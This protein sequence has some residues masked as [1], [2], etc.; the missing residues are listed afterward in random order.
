MEKH[1]LDLY[2][3]ALIALRKKTGQLIADSGDAASTVT[4]DQSKV[5]RLSRMDALQAQQMAQETVRRRKLQLQKIDNAL[6]R[7]E[8]GDYGD[9]FKCGEEI[10]EARLNFDPASTRCVGCMDS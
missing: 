6:R 4:L 8:S 2:Q 9:C 1:Q 3:N 7:I 5:G 10:A